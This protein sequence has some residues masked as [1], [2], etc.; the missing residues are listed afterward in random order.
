MDL[1]MQ[2]EAVCEGGTVEGVKT[3]RVCVGSN[4][5]ALDL[6]LYPYIINFFPV[7]LSMEF[8]IECYNLVF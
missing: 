5:R 8:L 6:D 3:G 4:E 1:G 2:G 7:L